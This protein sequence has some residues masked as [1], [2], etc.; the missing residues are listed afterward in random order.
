[1]PGKRGKM[2]M[3]RYIL[4]LDPSGSG[5]TGF[6]LLDTEKNKIKNLSDICVN[7]FKDVISY[8]DAHLTKIEKFYRAC[9]NDLIV[10][11]EDFIVSP[12]KAKQFIGSRMETNRLIGVIMHFCKNEGIPLKMIRP[13]DHLS[14][15]T[16]T[17]LCELDIIQK[18][19]R[20]Y[21]I[22]DGTSLNSHTKDAIRLAVFYDKLFN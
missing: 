10:A 2:K 13:I 15:F 8:W 7:N 17:T 6:C 12:K 11:M 16:D 14:R 4:G 20:G 21:S 1:M 3:Y 19:K 5:T 9:N 18:T 22:L